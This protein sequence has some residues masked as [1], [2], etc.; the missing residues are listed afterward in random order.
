[1]Q[2]SFQV[3]QPLKTEDIP[4]RGKSI[5]LS[6]GVIPATEILGRIG[7]GRTRAIN[8]EA[9]LD[10]RIR[11]KNTHIDLATILEITILETSLEKITVIFAIILETETALSLESKAF[12]EEERIETLDSQVIRDGKTIDL[13]NQGVFRVKIVHDSVTILEI[14]IVIIR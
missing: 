7:P 8:R 5:D 2:P 4:E 6:P 3:A 9:I 1:M 12:L 11:G 13:A 10:A 14:E